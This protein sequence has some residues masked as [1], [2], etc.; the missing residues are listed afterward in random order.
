[1]SSER[2]KKEEWRKTSLKV[3]LNKSL[4]GLW[5]DVLK[6]YQHTCSLSSY[7]PDLVFLFLAWERTPQSSTFSWEPTALSL[8]LVFWLL[9]Y[10]RNGCLKGGW[11]SSLTFC[12]IF[13]LKIGSLLRNKLFMMSLQPERSKYG[14]NSI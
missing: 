9:S 10:H 11:V 2:W 5:P 6:L 13:W 7:I 12:H 8:L 3:L 1:M 4:Y 14:Q